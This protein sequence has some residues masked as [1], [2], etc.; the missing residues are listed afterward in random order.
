MA[1]LYCFLNKEVGG[2]GQGGRCFGGS[3][4]TL[5]LPLR[6]ASPLCPRAL[7][8]LSCWDAGCQACQVRSASALH[9]ERERLPDVL[10]S[11]GTEPVWLYTQGTTLPFK[12]GSLGILGG[13]QGQAL[14]M[15]RPTC[16]P[17]V[18]SELLRRWHRWREG[19]ALQE[20]RHAGSHTTRPL[21]GPP[22]EKLLL[23]RG[24]GS[25]GTSQDPSTET[26]LAGGL[27]GSAE[28]PQ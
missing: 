8:G 21:G 14:G 22:S 1:I 12:A 25:N 20:E 26:R 10:F 18:Q 5:T 13:W 27:P 19:K 7:T 15:A 9:L 16:P 28:N 23:A 6:C 24:S 11:V 4:D 3:V 17:Q 2:G